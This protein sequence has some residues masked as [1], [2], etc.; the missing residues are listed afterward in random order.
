MATALASPP[1]RRKKDLAQELAGIRH[2]LKV[3]QNKLERQPELE[4]AITRLEILLSRLTVS[5]GGLL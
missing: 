3:L 1:K 5:S 2:L 4:E